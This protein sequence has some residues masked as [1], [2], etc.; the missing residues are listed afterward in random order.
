MAPCDIPYAISCWSPIV[1]TAI[2]V[3]PRGGGCLPVK[4]KKA[5]SASE[6]TRFTRGRLCPWFCAEVVL[7]MEVRLLVRLSGKAL[8][9][10]NVVTLCQARLVL[11]WM[12]VLGRV[13]YLGAEPGAQVYSA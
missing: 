11:E 7:R 8:V 2:T 4:P 1:S 9:S 12:I 13:N 5:G 3:V 6:V 10:I